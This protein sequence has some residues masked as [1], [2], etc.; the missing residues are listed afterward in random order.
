MKGKMPRITKVYTGKGDKGE[1]SLGSGRSV[2]K[3]NA[4]IQAYGAVDELNSFIGLALSHNLDKDL[5]EILT[6]VQQQL[7]DL[8]SDLCMPEKDKKSKP[9]P[10]IDEQDIAKIESSIDYYNGKLGHLKNFILPGGSAGASY[11]H[12]SRTICRRAEREAIALSRKERIGG[13]VIPYL[14]RLSS[15]LFNMA[16]YENS[17]EGYKEKYWNSRREE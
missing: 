2:R 11:L 12:I 13:F 3:D 6:E 17:K 10:V 8:G 5:E 15:L 14:N 9:V 4:R 16:R 7:F 1:T